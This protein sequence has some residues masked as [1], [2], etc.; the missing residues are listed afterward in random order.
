MLIHA[1]TLMITVI[2][3]AAPEGLPMMI[4]VVL[5]A[6]MKKMLSDNILVKKLVGIETTGS[7]NILY[8]DKTGT[9]TEGK[10][11]CDRIIT[12]SGT[13]RSVQGL[14]KSKEIL[15]YLKICARYNTDV[16]TDSFGAITG[17]NAT[18]RAIYSFFSHDE[19]ESVNVKNKIPFSSERKFSLITLKN[20][21]TN[22]R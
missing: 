18:D 15:R 4:T 12:A 22:N 6:N 8:T 11:E 17:G 7:M 16:T 3:V 10:P 9:I 20:G 19:C 14:K 2:V 1:L 21:E 5:S 13:Y